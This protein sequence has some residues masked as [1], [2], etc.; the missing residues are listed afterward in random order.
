MISPVEILIGLLLMLGLM[1]VGIHVATTMLVVGLLGA[2]IHFGLPAFNAL[3]EQI[4]AAG[5]DYLLLSIPLYILLG[6]ILMRGGATDKMYQSL[7]DWLQR[8]PGG[9][10]HT[11]I[12]AS[13]LFSAVSGSSVATAATIS[14]VAL[15]S[16][17]NRGYDQRMVLGSIAAGASLGNLIPPGVAFIIYGSMTNT[18]ASRLYM[19]GIVPGA[20]MTV[21]FLLTILAICVWRPSMA[22][23]P[24]GGVPWGERLKHSVHLAGPLL[25]FGVVM[26][27]IYTG[28]ATVTESAALG[29]IVCLPIAW[30]YGKLTVPMLHE[31]FRSTLRLTAMTA[32]ILVAALYLNFVLS[33]L[34]VPQSLASLIKSLDVSPLLLLWVLAVMYVLLG[35][36][37]E[38]MPMMVGTLPVVF[39]IIQA[40]GIDPIFFGVF[41]VLMC[42]LSLLSPPIGMTLYVIQGVRGE[43]SINEVFQGTLPFLVAM[44]AMTA[45]LIHFPAIA[46]WLPNLMYGR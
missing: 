7:A 12:G 43:G 9:L 6:E 32:L 4:W 25:V 35:V 10:L 8:L 29:V 2:V 24:E 3:G 40:A 30:G 11:N 39:P 41:M 33:M 31:C 45:I 42:E 15:P 5:E 34:G 44:I 26:G 16:F 17:K 37:L 21:L 46:T 38:T 36:A 14:T 23:K 19:A 27:G 20:I 13:A 22:G 1:F 28:W 18:S